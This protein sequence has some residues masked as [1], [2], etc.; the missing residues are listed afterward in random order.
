MVRKIIKTKKFFRTFEKTLQKYPSRVDEIAD[1]LEE[2][3]DYLEQAL[4]IPNKFK[5]HKGGDYWECHLCSRGSDIL[6]IYD[7]YKSGQE[8][9]IELIAITDHAK[10]NRQIRSCLIPLD[11]NIFE[12][13]LNELNDDDFYYVVDII[14]NRLNR[15][16]Q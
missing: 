15:N 6:L 2:L 12:K 1:S 5:N 11:L 16:L 3:Y 13:Y 4:A 9:I 7:K 10:L 8:V 14:E